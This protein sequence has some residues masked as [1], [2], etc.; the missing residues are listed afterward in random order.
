MSFVS[1]FQHKDYM[2]GGQQL[3]SCAALTI[4]NVQSQDDYMLKG[5]YDKDP[6]NDFLKH[7]T[8]L[9]YNIL[10]HASSKTAHAKQNTP[11]DE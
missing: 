7:A 2:I 3:F 1:Q 8:L 5:C 11:R 4:W 6:S 10:S 9:I